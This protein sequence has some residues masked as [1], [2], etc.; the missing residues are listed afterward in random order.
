MNFTN[1]YF[2]L[3]NKFDSILSRIMNIMDIQLT[4]RLTERDSVIPKSTMSP[5]HP[6]YMSK[7]EKIK[8]VSS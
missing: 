7:N 6:L 3:D 2:K 4:C 5:T 1:N 8:I